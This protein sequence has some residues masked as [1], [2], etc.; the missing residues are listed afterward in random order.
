MDAPLRRVVVQRTTDPRRCIVD[1]CTRV[2]AA[3]GYC[4]AHYQR[5][6]RGND[7][8]RQFRVGGTA[9]TDEDDRIL[10]WHIGMEPIAAIANRL[11]RG[12]EAIKRRANE[13]GLNFNREAERQAGYN[14]KQV[15]QM[16]GS[17][18]E[19]VWL[20]PSMSCP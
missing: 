1:G 20:C 3:A 5:A 15:S 16:L 6:K 12:T 19:S 7:M 8:L 4:N 11:G 18:P 14:L 2:H 13:R 9:W 17:H 10:S